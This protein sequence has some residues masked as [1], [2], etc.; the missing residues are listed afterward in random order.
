MKT[1]LLLTLGAFLS[2]LGRAQP[3]A[4]AAAASPT[5]PYRPV[6]HFAPPQNWLNDANGLVYS[7]GIYHLFYQHNPLS[8]NPGHLAW[9]HATSPD[10]L[11]WTSL[12]V[13]LREYQNPDGS[14]TMIFSGSAV[15]DEHNDSGLF[16]KGQTDGLVAFYTGHVEKNGATLAQHQNLAFSID[17]GLS[18]TRYAGNPVL[19]I[20]SK[21]FRDPKVFWYAPG[22]KWVMAC[23]KA[24]RQ[25]VY[26]YQST[27]PEGLAVY[28]PLGPGRRHGEGVGMPGFV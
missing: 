21:E 15:V 3:T 20:G 7:N 17:H 26:F 9:G 8:A 19:D 28:E 10:M 12:P 25:Q 24:D 14:N 13:A 27:E 4:P 22:R 16:A 11:H 18:W 6:Y 1:T 5:D 23:V 2:L